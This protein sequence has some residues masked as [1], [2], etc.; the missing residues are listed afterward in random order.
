MVMDLEKQDLDMQ[1]GSNNTILVAVWMVAYNQEAFIE[2]A[3]ESVM[4]QE[5]N[6]EYKLFIGEDCSTDNTREICIKLKQKYPEKIELFL[7]EKNVGANKNAQ[8]IFKKC[9]DS[10]AKYIA[11]LEGDDYWT[12]VHK[13]Q[14]QVNCLDANPEYSLCF[15]DALIRDGKKTLYQYVNKNENIFKTEDLFERHFI[16]TSSMFFRNSLQLPSWYDKIQSGDK[17]LLF[18]ISLKGAFKYLPEVMS[19]YRIHSGGISKTH[20][21]IKKVYDSAHLLH[22]IDEETNYK[23]NKNCQESLLYEIETHILPKYS[24]KTIKTK[25]LIN[26]VLNR[27]IKRFKKIFK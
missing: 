8:L 9:F 7:H 16:P 20:H 14:K 27:I 6:F 23:F 1:F 3:I 25:V 4:S 21:G 22:L 19:V 5:A 10:E 15:H 17:V 24:I 18:L 11:L 12:D 2:K 26:E 13:L